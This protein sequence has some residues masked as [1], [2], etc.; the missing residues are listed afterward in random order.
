[1]THTLLMWLGDEI[2]PI[3]NQLELCMVYL[4]LSLLLGDELC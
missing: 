3:L 2:G 4:Y 1:M